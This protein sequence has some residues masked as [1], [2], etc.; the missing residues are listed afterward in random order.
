MG[1][2]PDLLLRTPK[3]FSGW[4]KDPISQS[5]VLPLLLTSKYSSADWEAARELQR[6]HGNWLPSTFPRWL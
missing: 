5:D 6:S 4:N 3:S 2:C 1:T